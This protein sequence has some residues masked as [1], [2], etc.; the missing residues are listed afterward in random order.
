GATLQNFK[1]L[2]A[3]PRYKMRMCDKQAQQL[4]C[5]GCDTV[6]RRRLPARPAPASRRGRTRRDSGVSRAKR[7]VVKRRFAPC[8]TIFEPRRVRIVARLATGTPFCP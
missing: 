4:L 5:H 7:R 3:Q 8:A 1:L 2:V 6:T